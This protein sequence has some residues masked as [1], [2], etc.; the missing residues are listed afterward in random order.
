MAE[1]IPGVGAPVEDN[2]IGA[3]H[4]LDSDIDSWVQGHVGAT[5]RKCDEAHGS[6]TS[7]IGTFWSLGDSNSVRQM[8][9]HL[10]SYGNEER[11]RDVALASEVRSSSRQAPVVDYYQTP[12][13]LT[14][15]A[16]SVAG[17]DK[18]D[19]LQKQTE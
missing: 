2:R 15:P 5:I 11:R 13:G 10:Y 7:R 19:L 8:A 1:R 9:E 12:H 17:S 3:W 4:V 16:F 6:G 18:L 14:I